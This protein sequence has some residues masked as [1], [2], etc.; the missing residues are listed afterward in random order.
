MAGACGRDRKAI[1][2]EE[3]LRV[4]GWQVLWGSR[5]RSLSNILF[6]PGNKKVCLLRLRLGEECGESDGA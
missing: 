4:G 1:T 6:F 5:R 2:Q 3:Q